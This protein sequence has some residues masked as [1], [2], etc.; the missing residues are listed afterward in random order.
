MNKSPLKF[1]FTRNLKCLSSLYMA[2][3]GELCMIL[4]QSLLEKLVCYKRISGGFA[5]E[6]KYLYSQFI[7]VAVKENREKFLSFDMDEDRVDTFCGSI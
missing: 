2:G 7:N 3:C 4:F 6:A 1:M 5:D